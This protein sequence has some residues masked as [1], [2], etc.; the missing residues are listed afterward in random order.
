MTDPDERPEPAFTLD[1]TLVRRFI[2][3]QA[4]AEEQARLAGQV[5]R[6]MSFEAEL[7]APLTARF[8]NVLDHVGGEAALIEWLTSSPACPAEPRGCS[9]SSSCSTGSAANEPWWT[10]WRSTPSTPRIRL[11]CAGSSLR[12]QQ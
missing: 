11:G 8:N 12:T 7:P 5:A 6:L 2:T 4:D 9:C 1:P 3:G 10:R